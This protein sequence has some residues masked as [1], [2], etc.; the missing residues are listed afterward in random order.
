MS[1]LS[2]QIEAVRIAESRVAEQR[3]SLERNSRRL[4]KRARRLL[5]PHGVVVGGLL[6]GVLADRWLFPPD[7]P[8]R[9]NEEHG[10]GSNEGSERTSFLAEIG[11]LLAIANSLTPLAMNAMELHQ[12]W[13]ASRAPSDSDAGMNPETSDT[14]GST[15]DADALKETSA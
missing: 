15:S 4:A 6:A 11:S 3:D 2:R 5:M 10:S 8:K 14:A 1:S 12:R 9:S 7:S 13:Q